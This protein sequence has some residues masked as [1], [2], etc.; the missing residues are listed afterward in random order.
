MVDTVIQ[1]YRLENAPWHYEHGLQTQAIATVGQAMGEARYLEFAQAWAD[2]FVQADGNIRSYRLDEFNLDQ[3]N[4]GKVLFP[5]FERSGEERYALALRLLREQLRNQ[6]R[7]PSNGFWHKQIYPNQMW[8]DGIYMTGPFYAEYGRVF[9]EPAAFDDVAHQILLIEARTRD[10]NSGLLYHAWD[11]SH[12]QP[13]AHAETG[14]SP[15][16]WGRAMGW[17]G[18]AL[19]DVLDHFPK[20]HLKRPEI[21]AVLERFAQAVVRVQDPLTGLWFQILDQPERPGNYREASASAMFVYALAK[22]VRKGLLPLETL[23]AARRGYHGLLENQIRVD[24]HGLL[25]LEG[26]CRSAGLGGNPYR[27]GSFEYYIS[28]PVIADDPKG[29]GAFILAA[30]EMEL[31]R[32]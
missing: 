19:V 26:I 20:N 18:M 23:S 30:L 24:A 7:T 16:F 32:I 17:Y 21:V 28:E 10:A 22:G 12:Q 6:P 31:S 3:I 5:I 2:R 29:V 27:D 4:P 25:T 1:G 9:H 14:C 13:W 8:L 15:H 11:E